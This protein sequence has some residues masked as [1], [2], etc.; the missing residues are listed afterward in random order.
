M[1]V[2]VL[3]SSNAVS[4]GVR[5]ALYLADGLNRQGH[6]VHFVCPPGGET[7]PLIK[8]MGLRHAALPS[9]LLEADKVLRALMPPKEPVVV[10]GFHNRGVKLVSYL[11]TYWRILGLPVA[12]VAHRGVTARPGNPLPYLLPGIRAYVV[13]SQACMDLL[14]LLWRRWRCHVVS[15]SIPENRLVPARSRQEVRNALGIPDNCRIIGNVSNDNPLKGA[16]QAIKAFALARPALLPVKLVVV[17]VSR[18][19]WL[20]LCNELGVADDV[21]LV[22]RVNEVADFMQVMDILVFPSLFIESQPNVI[23]EGM[24]MGLPVIAGDIGGVRELL[25]P[26][27]LFDPKDERQVSACLVRLMKDP[28]A[29]RRLAEANFAQKYRFSTEYRLETV[30]R[31]YREVLREVSA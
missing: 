1:N 15:N 19:K 26:E 12:G 5:Q 4:G 20:P 7:E 11:C 18:E 28:A 31:I 25:P 3:T 23:M 16:G 22:P 17:G 8:E 24:S 6:S 13:N 30:T 9:S 29:M 14:P 2:I 27:C 10:H 21:I